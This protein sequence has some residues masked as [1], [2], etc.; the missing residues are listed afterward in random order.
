[1]EAHIDNDNIKRN[2]STVEAQ[3]WGDKKRFLSRDL[4]NYLW[5]T[6]DTSVFSKILQWTPIISKSNERKSEEDKR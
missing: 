1:V 2:L 3:E 4:P 6:K 5:E